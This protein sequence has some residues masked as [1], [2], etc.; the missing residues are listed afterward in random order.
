MQTNIIASIKDREKK[1]TEDSSST[2]D[3]CNCCLPVWGKLEISSYLW[4]QVPSFHTQ[5]LKCFIS[6][7]FCVVGAL[8]FLSL[9]CFSHRYINLPVRMQ[10]RDTDLCKGYTENE[11]PRESH[12][13]PALRFQKSCKW[14]ICCL[15]AFC[16]GQAPSILADICLWG[17]RL[18]DGTVGFLSNVSMSVK[19]YRE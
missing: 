5:L 19:S 18:G 14:C 13:H 2:W 11:S 4:V 7:W 15:L 12:R 6:S 3:W 9:F 10:K 8:L 16:T 1:I 17:N